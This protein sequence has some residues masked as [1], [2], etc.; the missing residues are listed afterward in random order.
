M[1]KAPAWPG[2]FATIGSDLVLAGTHSIHVYDLDS[3]R[4][5]LRT[6]S[7]A[8][9]DV[10]L[11]DPGDGVTAVAL[12]YR[13]GAVRI[14]HVGRTVSIR[15]A[16]N[17]GAVPLSDGAFTDRPEIA[18]DPSTRTVIEASL[19]GISRYAA[20]G[21]A[22]SQTSWSEFAAKAGLPGWMPD[23]PYDLTSRG[24]YVMLRPPM[25]D[26]PGEAVSGAAVVSTEGD[27][28]ARFQSISFLSA[29]DAIGLSAADEDTSLGLYQLP[30]AKR[31]LDLPESEVA[32]LA[33]NTKT[34]AYAVGTQA[35]A[36]GVA[37]FDTATSSTIGSPLPAPPHAQAVENIA[38]SDDSRY[39]IVT[40]RIE[41]DRDELFVYVVDPAEW[42]RMLCLWA[43]SQ[44]HESERI[45]A[46]YG[47]MPPDACEKYAGQ[48]LSSQSPAP[49]LR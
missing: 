5:Q 10:R 43:G 49:A 46:G 22:V 2:S 1:Q 12:N 23:L 18:Y 31:V 37:L 36:T 29:E 13:S 11:S 17:A 20:T 27:L 15:D 38:F 19:D 48:I 28:I 40:Y 6:A 41:A 24:S 45:N 44:P 47:I 25:S 21:R 42:Q 9:G 7:D 8:S 32:A 4:S 34:I 39:L 3:Y 16:F 26:V 30:G 14:M 35:T 33:P